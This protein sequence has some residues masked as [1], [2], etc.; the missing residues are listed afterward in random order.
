MARNTLLIQFSQQSFDIIKMYI[1]ST[2]FAVDFNLGYSHITSLLFCYSES[3]PHGHS[4][5]RTALLAATFTKPRF[6]QLP[7]KLCIFTFP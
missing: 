3:S 4:R 2:G 5:K 7:Y 6:S 1:R